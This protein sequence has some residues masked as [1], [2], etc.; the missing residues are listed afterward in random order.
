MGPSLPGPPQWG[1]CPTAGLRWH[2]APSGRGQ[3]AAAADRTGIGGSWLPPLPPPRQKIFSRAPSG[4]GQRAAAADTDISCKPGYA[5]QPRTTFCVLPCRQ[6]CPW[7]PGCVTVNCPCPPASGDSSRRPRS[8]LC[9]KTKRIL[10]AFTL[11]FFYVPIF[12]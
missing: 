11:L 12:K 4:R 8:F 1:S 3:K 5:R 10:K 6:G 7:P 9:T 2:R